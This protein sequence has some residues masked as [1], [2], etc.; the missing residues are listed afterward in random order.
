[1]R[2]KTTNMAK[3][4]VCAALYMDLWH[5]GEIVSDN[6][7]TQANILF[8]DYGTI[9]YV[10]VA[11]LRYLRRDFANFPGQA[12]RGSLSFIRPIALRW[13]FDSTDCLLNM[14]INKVLHAKVTN[15]D[16]KVCIFPKN[17]GI[18]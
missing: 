18:N 16:D 3:G 12:Y 1:M 13:S 10:K 2:L 8:V 9:D 4:Q 11:D 5:R 14:V 15:I 7:E 17:I 6:N